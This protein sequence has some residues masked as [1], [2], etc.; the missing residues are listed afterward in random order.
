MLYE[1]LFLLP[2]G[3]EGNVL[4]T[5]SSVLLSKGGG[6]VGSVEDGATQPEVEAVPLVA[7]NCRNTSRLTG[8]AGRDSKGQAKRATWL[9]RHL[10]RDADAVGDSK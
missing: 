5:L 2:L 9:P 6:V 7:A 8:S 3:L 4:E 10:V 1:D